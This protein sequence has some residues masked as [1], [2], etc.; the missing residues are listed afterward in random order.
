MNVTRPWKRWASF[1]PNESA[2]DA[3]RD[4]SGGGGWPDDTTI[5]D[6]DAIFANSLIL[7]KKSGID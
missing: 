1:L 3:R 6:G 5:I 2:D 4:Q 7:R